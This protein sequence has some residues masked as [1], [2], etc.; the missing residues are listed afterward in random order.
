MAQ[1]QFGDFLDVNFTNSKRAIAGNGG[2]AD[3]L[4]TPGNYQDI[5]TIDAALK[6]FDAFTYSDA[7]LQLMNVNDK[8]FA[9]RCIADPTTIANY[10]PAQTA[11]TS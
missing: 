11:R 5:T 9:Y 6:A 1:V 8:I 10:I 4:T 2:S 3:M 7:K